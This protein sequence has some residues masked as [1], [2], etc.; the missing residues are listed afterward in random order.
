MT[1][2][3]NLPALRQAARINRADQQRAIYSLRGEVGRLGRFALRFPDSWH[4]LSRANPAKTRR[5]L[6]RLEELGLVQ[7]ARYSPAARPAG[8]MFKLAKLG[9]GR[10]DWPSDLEAAATC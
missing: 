9:G 3:A 7:I 4:T 6:L 8:D 1:H 10:W 5:A 2:V